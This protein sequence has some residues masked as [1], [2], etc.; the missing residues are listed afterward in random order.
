MANKKGAATQKSQSVV[1]K[2]GGSKPAAAKVAPK[3]KSNKT[4]LIIAA[5]GVV[6][7]I[8]I[9]FAANQG[10]KKAAATIPAD[11]AKYIGRYLP[12]DYQEP[13][14]AEPTTYNQTITMTP[15]TATDDGK[16]VS[17]NTADVTNGKIVSFEV[18]RA[19][20][21]SVPMVAYVKPS[22]KLFVGVS[23]C[24]PCQGTGQRIDADGTLTCETCGTKRT[25]ETGVGLSG[26]CKLYPLD[27]LTASV[28]GGKITV[29]KS[30]I[31]GWQL[32][33]KDRQVGG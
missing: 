25:L 4:A 33:P 14:V 3:R 2:S 8:G 27:E 23:Y 30:A 31:E 17:L 29:Q 21:Q 1:N 19:D 12:K 15:V 10:A 24:V 11:E 18:K 13:K 22:G 32:Q 28:A 26:A 16:A 9:L 5:V 6:A 20:G 7:V